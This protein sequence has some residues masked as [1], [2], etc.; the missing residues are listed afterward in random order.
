MFWVESES[1]W[2]LFLNCLFF[3]PSVHPR[4][5]GYVTQANHVPRVYWI[6][7]SS[8]QKWALVANSPWRFDCFLWPRSL[9]SGD[10]RSPVHGFVQEPSLCSSVTATGANESRKLSA[11]VSINSKLQ[12]VICKWVSIR[13]HIVQKRP[14]YVA[15]KVLQGRW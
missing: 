9:P 3:W 5:L 14:M 7:N 13:K 8:S 12:K 6:S 2:R 10:V 15:R 4:P 11:H 1:L